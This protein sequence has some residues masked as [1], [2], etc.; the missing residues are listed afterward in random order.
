MLKTLKRK[1]EDTPLDQP[2]QYNTQ[3]DKI[4][5]KEELVYLYMNLI[6]LN[7]VIVLRITVLIKFS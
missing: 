3:T 6:L 7:Y 4:H 1:I 5:I 2:P